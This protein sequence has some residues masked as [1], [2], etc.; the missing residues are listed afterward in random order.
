MCDIRAL[1]DIAHAGRRAAGGGQLLLQ[2][3]AAAPGR[4][5]APIMVMHSGTKY[6]DGQ[7]R[8]IAG[9]LVRQLRR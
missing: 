6:L 4:D 7:G 3:R 1:A 5:W 8:V 9:A 2:P